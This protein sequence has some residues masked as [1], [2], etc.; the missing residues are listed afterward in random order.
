MQTNVFGINFLQ[1]CKNYSYRKNSVHVCETH[2]S[3]V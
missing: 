1:F 2:L 3:V